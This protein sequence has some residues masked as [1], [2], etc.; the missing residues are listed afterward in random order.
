MHLVIGLGNPGKQYQKTRHNVGF[1]VLDALLEKEKRQDPSL[2]WKLSKK[3]NAEIAIL[4]IGEK[5]I[6]LAKPM[7]FMNNSGQSTQLLMQ[8]YN[9][10][11]TKL[12]VVHDEKDLPL[13]SLKKQTDRGHAGHNGIKSIIQH[14]GTKEFSRIR[15]GIAAKKIKKME[16]TAKFVLG[17]FGIFEKKDLQKAIN[18]SIEEIYSLVR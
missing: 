5:K 15:V 12:T 9:I 7:T 17:R 2:S 6:V 16:N 13:G 11:H 14:I 8:Y 10:P 4:H 1:M 18:M 3:H